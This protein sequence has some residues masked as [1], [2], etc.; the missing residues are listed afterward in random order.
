M[1]YEKS[2][3]NFTFTLQP[4]HVLLSKR[5]KEGVDMK[6]LQAKETK[7]FLTNLYLSIS[8]VFSIWLASKWLI[9]MDIA[10]SC[11]GAYWHMEQFHIRRLEQALNQSVLFLFSLSSKYLK[12]FAGFYDIYAGFLFQFPGILQWKLDHIR[13]IVESTFFNKRNTIFIHFHK[14]C[15]PTLEICF[16]HVRT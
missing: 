10:N 15:Y 2:L 16:R 4:K 8:A 5:E 14:C 6:T 1:S 7:A 12:C 9:S 11:V 13:H 3:T